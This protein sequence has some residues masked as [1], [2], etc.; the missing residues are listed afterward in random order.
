M[1]KTPKIEDL[2]DIFNSIDSDRNGFV[3]HDE[4]YDALGRSHFKKEEI[5]LLISQLDKNNDGLIDIKGMKSNE[6]LSIL[7]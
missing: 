2:V 5:S 6:I 4:F 1:P 7:T 3:T